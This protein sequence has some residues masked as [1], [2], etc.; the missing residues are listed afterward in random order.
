MALFSEAVIKE[1]GTTEEEGSKNAP[2]S[3]RPSELIADALQDDGTPSP[4][5]EDEESEEQIPLLFVDVNL[6]HDNFKRIVLYEGDDPED[7][8]TQFSQNNS[9][10]VTPDLDEAMEEKLKGLLKEQIKTVLVKINE[11]D[12]EN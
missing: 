10:P 9:K 12:E 7:V 1:E 5:P 4:A 6:G 3:A 8:A 2:E 11:D